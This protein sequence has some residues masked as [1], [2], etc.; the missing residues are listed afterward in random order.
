MRERVKWDSTHNPV[1]LVDMVH[2]GWVQRLLLAADWSGFPGPEAGLVE[3]GRTRVGVQAKR[4]FEKLAE[5]DIDY[6]LEPPDSVPGA[7]WIRPVT[8]VLAFRQATCVDLCV[9]FCCAALDAGIYPL[10]LT[11]TTAD[12]KQRHSI[13]IVPLGRTWSTGC[14]A[15]I[16]SGY[17]REPLAVDGGALAGVVAQDA[18]DP[19][20][21]WLAIDVQQAMMPEGDWGTALSRG[22]DYLQKWKWD[23]CVDVGGQR[24]HKADDA[25]PPGGKHIERVLVPAHTPLPSDSTPLQLIRARHAVVPFQKRSE[26]RELRRWATT[27]ACTSTNTANGGGADIAVAVV[28]GVGGSG[29][30]RMAAQLCH[31]LSSI[32]WYAGFLPTTTD[33]TDQELAAL[34][35]I[36]TEL[37]VV[38]DY[39]EE[40]QRDRLAKVFRALRV[41]R[42]PTRIVLT[43]RG[44][45]AWW[46][47]FREEVEQ[48]GISLS[49]TLVISKL[50]KDRQEEDQGLLNR[51]YIRAVR[52]FSAKLNDS[53]PQSIGVPEVLGD[54]ALDA[55]LRAWLAVYDEQT[56]T[57]EEIPAPSGLYDKVLAIEFSQWR[58]APV[59]AEISTNHMR[60]AAATLSLLAPNQDED[61]IDEVLSRLPEWSTEH[62]RRSRFAE[63]LVHTLLHGDSGDAVSV[64]P[65]PVA[66]YLILKVFGKKP[67]LLDQVL[68][69]DPLEVP[70]IEDLDADEMEIQRALALRQQVQNAC[71]AITRAASHDLKVARRL[72][73]RALKT[74][75]HLWRRALDVAL[76]QG[77]PFA[78][79]LEQLIASGADLPLAEI[80]K[81]IPLG[82]GVLRGAALAA[83]KRLAASAERSPEQQA[84]WANTL[85]TRLSDVG[86]REGA[87]GR[88]GRRRACTGRWPRN[89]RRPTPPTWPRR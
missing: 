12:G 80:T 86:D 15:V 73:G 1:G 42:A 34:E 69:P 6:V 88:R 27:P 7:Q 66:E 40:A 52:G 48:D 62:L 51:I 83:T 4:I 5:L 70:G 63:L 8:E 65:D 89:S 19:T 31:D 79:A 29:K 57:A 20:G 36:T 9:T 25:V 87:L 33:V 76:I 28:T 55:V 21:T 50:G 47:E 61:E 3:D 17:S 45:D 32:G 64:R 23:V 71:V 85:A 10:V 82:H 53:I 14:D 68:P 18:D 49:N 43:A 13:V 60:R 30:T 81:V 2:A 75:P 11:L 54:T 78:P 44:A 26:L 39:A 77:G 24:S 72:A 59:L 84:R 74:H 67:D 37:M 58:K 35:E 56:D 46:D 38:V 16:E 22:A 41:R